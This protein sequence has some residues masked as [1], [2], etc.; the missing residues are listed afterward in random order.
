MHTRT[1]HWPQEQELYKQW[2][3][4]SAPENLWQSSN[5]VNVQEALG[6]EVRMYIIEEE[7]QIIASALVVIDTTMFGLSTWEIPRG[8]IWNG[9]EQVAIKLL[10][11]IVADAKKERCMRMY[12]SPFKSIEVP[13]Q[14]KP[15]NRLVH[16]THTIQLDLTLDEEELLQQMKPKGRY[17]CK[18]AT[19]H[20]VTVGQSTDA[21]AFAQL[22]ATTGSRNTF[23]TPNNNTYQRFID[24]INGSFLLY[25]YHPDT[26]EPIAGLIGVC[27]GNL[28][29]YYYGAS[30]HVYRSSMAPYA[31][32]QAAIT[33][34]K[35]AGCT[36]YDL[37]GIA[38]PNEPKHPWHGITS[39]KEKFGGTTVTIAPEQQMILKPVSHA[40]LALKRRLC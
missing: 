18:V 39:F 14:W 36:V 37:F 33:H 11:F 31:L 19:K 24:V 8:P 7:E 16:P 34:C 20:G 12:I 22:H 1:L 32:Q 4:S 38:P 30:N 29:I 28:G 35:A 13:K 6:R 23:V 9:D 27:Q 3:E 25:A 17:N 40:L 26:T 10:E 5:W 15:S 21:T 2:I